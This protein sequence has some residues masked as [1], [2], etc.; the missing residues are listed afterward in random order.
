MDEA[1][2][3][4]SCIIHVFPCNFHKPL[5]SNTHLPGKLFIRNKNLND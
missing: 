3:A 2:G 4:L 5:K 1:W